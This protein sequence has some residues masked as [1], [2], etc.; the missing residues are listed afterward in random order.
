[1]AFSPPL[2]PS[3]SPNASFSVDPP[4]IGAAWSR[5]TFFSPMKRRCQPMPIPI[6][7]VAML[8]RYLDAIPEIDGQC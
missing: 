6:E 2:Q 4:R 8:K 3:L 1:M 5:A 7:D